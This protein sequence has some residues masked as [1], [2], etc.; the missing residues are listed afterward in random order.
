[1]PRV[2]PFDKRS[3]EYE[4]WFES[5]FF[6]YLSELR[7]VK[8]QLPEK[9]RCL[10]IGAGSGRFAAPLGVELG[11][12]PS[13]RMREIAEKRGIT[14]VDGVGENLPC[15]DAEF[16]AALMVTTVC[17]LD[18]VRASFAE[19]HRV[20]KPGGCIVVGF[21]DKDSRIG[22]LY[23]QL[24]AKSPFYRI[25]SFYSASEV[26]QLLKQAGFRDI[27]FVQTIFR[28]LP[29]IVQVEPIRPGSG[30]GSFLVARG[31]K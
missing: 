16:D 8:K 1:M 13:E 14:V 25:A 22:R 4:E 30:E 3:G 12:E 11:V 29:E 28:D 20:I 31:L 7:A 19:A 23:Q 17:F 24:R 2:E 27:S 5:N 21:I 6:A 15:K 10:E 9:G 26:L 18:D